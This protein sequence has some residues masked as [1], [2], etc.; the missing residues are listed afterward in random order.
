MFKIDA[1][2]QKLA[3]AAQTI[4]AC[5]AQLG[6]QRDETMT[7]MDGRVRYAELVQAAMGAYLTGF[8]QFRGKS[9]DEVVEFFKAQV[10]PSLSAMPHLIEEQKAQ[11][12]KESDGEHAQTSDR[13][14]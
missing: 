2:T 11:S 6:D 13:V 5:V 9:A 1:M 12:P 8:G 7:Q 4:S 10:S 14:A 3:D